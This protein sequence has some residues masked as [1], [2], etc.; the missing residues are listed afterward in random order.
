LDYLILYQNKLVLCKIIS[1][2]STIIL[3]IILFLHRDSSSVNEVD[4]SDLALNDQIEK[5]SIILQIPLSADQNEYELFVL[6]ER[7]Q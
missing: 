6:L 2:E 3:R 1:T 5:P 7:T 4:P